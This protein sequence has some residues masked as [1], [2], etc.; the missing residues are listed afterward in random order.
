[1]LGC[2]IAILT[3]GRRADP[4]T[5]PAIIIDGDTIISS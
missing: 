3:F 2:L 1:M 4:L 5:G